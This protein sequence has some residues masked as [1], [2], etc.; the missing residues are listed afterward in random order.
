MT[1]K[2]GN[3]TIREALF[4]DAEQL[5]E[6]WGN[7]K[8]MA[9]AGFPNGLH[10]DPEKLRNK[11][12]N[13]TDNF[14]IFIIEL[15]GEPIG[16]MNYKKL[17]RDTASIGIKICD[18]TKHNQGLG[19]TL[20]AM[21]I[22]AIFRRYGYQKIILDTNAENKRAIHTYQKLGF[23]IIKTNKDSWQNQ[24]GEMQSSVDLELKKEDWNYTAI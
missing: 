2:Q 24:L 4:S 5:C 17:D 1:L 22:D 18:F 8:I 21:F 15:H 19:T 16:E 14:R 12:I 3:L 11:L 20:L 23:K 9:H 7:G 6:W 10:T 13:A